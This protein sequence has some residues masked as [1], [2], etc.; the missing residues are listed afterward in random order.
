[1]GGLG[2]GRD[3]KEIL[4]FG[5]NDLSNKSYQALAERNELNRS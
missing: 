3:E 5:V 2:K 4:K 1:M